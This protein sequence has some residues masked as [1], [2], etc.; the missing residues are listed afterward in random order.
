MDIIPAIDLLAGR[1]VRLFQGN[2]AKVTHYEA[3]PA[4]LAARYRAAGA[5]RLHVVDLDGARTGSPANLATIASL[6]ANR[7][8]SVQAGGGI[9]SRAMVDQ[10]LAAG[11]A[12]VVIGSAAVNDAA[13]ALGWF[14]SAGADRFVLAFDVKIDPASGE[15]HAVTHGW[16]EQSGRHLW[17]LM[18]QFL[19][20]GARHFLCTDVGRDG[21][22]SGPNNALYAE[23]ARR[24]PQARILASGG[25]ARAAD[26]PALAAT[27]VAGV[28]VGRALLDGSLT[29]E[30]MG[31]FWRAG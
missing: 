9:R 30:E 6:A 21:T 26:L 5:R 2:F 3:E 7:E 8:L 16:R 28:I 4:A 22:L 31:Q 29:L 23:C 13:T 10:L 12:Q 19:A 14:A 27:G 17:E 11:V 15:P 24:F 25:V 20:A 18:E 1:C